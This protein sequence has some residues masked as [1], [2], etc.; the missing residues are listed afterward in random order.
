M[1]LANSQDYKIKR[2]RHRVNNN[3]TRLIYTKVELRLKKITAHYQRNS[4]V[5]PTLGNRDVKSF[6]ESKADEYIIYY[7][8][9][10]LDS[11]G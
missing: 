4:I 8:L 2:S 5:S 7:T 3:S 1:T 9:T 10:T 6:V 11:G